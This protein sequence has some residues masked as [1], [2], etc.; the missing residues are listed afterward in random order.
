MKNKSSL[1]AGVALGVMLAMGAGAVAQAK[2]VKKRHIVEHAHVETA[3]EAKVA[4]LTQAV[5]SLEARLN[6]EEAA[7]KATEAQAQAA[8]ADAAQARADAQAAHTQLQ[9][10]I[11]TIPE[12]VKAA[13]DAAKPK[14]DKLYI[15]GV[16]VQ[17]G[18]FLAAEGVYRSKSEEADIASSF[19][20]IPYPNGVLGHADEGRFTARQS[21]VTALIQG[22]VTSTIHL[23]GY[24]E[25]D[26]LGAAQ[27]ANSNETNSY[28][29]R[30][31]VLYST[32]N[33]DDADG[34]W[35]FLAGQSWSLATQ[36]S[37]GLNVRSELLPSVIDAQYVPG[38]VFTRQPQL[39]LTR[40]W[41]NAFFVGLSLENPQTTYFNSG[42]FLPGISVLTNGAAGSGFNSANTLSLNHVPDVIGKVATD[43]DLDG[44]VL[45]AEAFGIYRDFYSR[46]NNA[47][48]A[49]NKDVSGGG[50]GGAFSLGVVPKV[51]DVQFS[52]AYGDGIGRYGAGQLPDSTVSVDG[53]LH[54]IKEY[55]LLVG[56]TLHALPTLDVYAYAG[57]EHAR[58]QQ[59]SSGTIYNGLGNINYDNSGCETEGASN[60][61]ANNR[62]VEQVTV[63]FWHKPYVGAFGHYQW[64]FQ[65]SYTERH[66]F[67]G[68]GGAPE[69]NDSMFL[70][71]FRYYP[72]N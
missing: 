3:L 49:S 31:R 40:N 69:T 10:Q 68:L 6:D 60:C 5:S 62:S 67:A 27:T 59:Y 44:H 1:R 55:A 48:V 41:Q 56:A 45:H 43:Q 28:N 65:Y 17:L 47:G 58:Q 2:P 71:S 63:G 53:T 54:P 64:G 12:D 7:R 8:Q 35:Q 33:W 46:L 66:A 70:Y 72:F 4:S 34:G 38:F 24:G 29:P 14:T 18:G 19:S 11:Q 57:E 21:R 30:I 20:G 51:L 16:S 42:K 52:G 39:R 37:K 25:V 13:V 32:V 26:F 36:Y 9:A 61:V 15:K 50:F 23:T 22:D